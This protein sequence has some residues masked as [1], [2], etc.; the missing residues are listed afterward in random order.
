MEELAAS[1]TG[2]G[3]NSCAEEAVA[4]LVCKWVFPLCAMVRIISDT[5][6]AA[7]RPRGQDKHDRPR[8]TSTTRSGGAL[9]Q[10]A[11][12]TAGVLPLDAIVL[13]VPGQLAIFN[14]EC[15]QNGH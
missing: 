1:F 15:A 2:C 6:R 3:T 5:S 8:Q 9:N 14:L 12:G 7:I 11:N 4:S 13:P 10:R